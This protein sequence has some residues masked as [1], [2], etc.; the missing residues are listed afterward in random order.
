MCLDRFVG[1]FAWAIAMAALLSM[2]SGSGLSSS[3]VSINGMAVS[4]EG[5]M[6]IFHSAHRRSNHW[7]SR[8]AADA[9]IYSDSADEFA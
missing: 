5:R 4:S 1:P 7:V 8:Q 6:G 9:D 3:R 2:C